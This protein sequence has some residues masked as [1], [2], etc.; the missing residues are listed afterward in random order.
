MRQTDYHW[1][2]RRRN[3]IQTTMATATSSQG[4][5]RKCMVFEVRQ[6]DGKGHERP[7]GWPWRLGIRPDALRTRI[8]QAEIDGAIHA[9]HRHHVHCRDRRNPD[10]FA[11]GFHDSHRVGLQPVYDDAVG[12][13]VIPQGF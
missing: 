8:R 10:S 5:N 12:D 3:L 1:E 7:P 2:R 6:R 13:H 9:L 11:A 4:E